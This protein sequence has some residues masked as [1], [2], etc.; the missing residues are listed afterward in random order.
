MRFAATAMIIQTLQH[1][2]VQKTAPTLKK[3]GLVDARHS[4]MSKSPASLMLDFSL[5]TSKMIQKRKTNTANQ[6][7]GKQEGV[8]HSPGSTTNE[9]VFCLHP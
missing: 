4:K 2:V 7:K 3:I 1:H 9:T 5:S 8:E 6:Q